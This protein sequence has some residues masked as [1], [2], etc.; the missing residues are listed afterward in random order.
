MFLGARAEHGHALV[1]RGLVQL[2]QC[3]RAHANIVAGAG[4][5]VPAHGPAADAGAQQRRRYMLTTGRQP[6]GGIGRLIEST[7]WCVPC[8]PP[9]PA[10]LPS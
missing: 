10:P 6:V 1:A 9:L 2:A 7:T 3:D 5:R 4:G 8:A